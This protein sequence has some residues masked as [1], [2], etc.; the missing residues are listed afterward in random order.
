MGPDT[1]AKM[2]REQAETHECTAASDRIPALLPRWNTVFELGY[3]SVHPLQKKATAD[4][5]SFTCS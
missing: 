5:S 2:K 4:C 3:V 1:L